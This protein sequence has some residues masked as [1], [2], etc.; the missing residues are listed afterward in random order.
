MTQAPSS[1]LP[2]GMRMAENQLASQQLPPTLYPSLS[3]SLLAVLHSQ[4][5]L[6]PEG[7]K[8]DDLLAASAA[9]FV[10]VSAVDVERQKIT[11]MAPSPLVVPS[12]VLL[13]GSVKWSAS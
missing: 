12:I 6:A 7:G 3:Y 10:W 8:C 11:L 1:A 13:Q 2:I 5:G 9:G 4:A